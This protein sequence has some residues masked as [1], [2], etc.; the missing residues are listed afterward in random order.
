MKDEKAS[1]AE[2]D[3]GTKEAPA[4]D[5]KKPQACCGLVSGCS[6]AHLSSALIA[7]YC[8]FPQTCLAGKRCCYF[9]WWGAGSSSVLLLLSQ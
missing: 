9:F 3:K 6:P 1:G 5:L 8:G 2:I 4:C 7:P